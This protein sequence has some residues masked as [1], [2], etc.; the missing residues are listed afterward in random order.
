MIPATDLATV[1]DWTREQDITVTLVGDHKQLS[2]IGPSGLFPRMLQERP[3]AELD[4]NLRQRSEVGRE[5]AAFLRDG[6]TEAAFTLLADTGQLV[7]VA[8]QAEAERTLVDAWAERAATVDDSFERLATCGIESQRN[9]QV[10]I[11]NALARTTARDS[12]WLTGPDTRYRIRNDEVT[13]AVGDQMIVTRNIRRRDGTVLANG[14]R[15]IVEETP[16]AGLRIVTRDDTGQH[17]RDRL[18]PSQTVRST[19]HGYAMTTHKLQGQTVTSLVVDVGPDR[20]LSATYVA[21]TRHRDDVFAVVNI[22]DIA[23]GP[24]IERLIAAGPDA[25]RDAVIAITANRIRQRGFADSPT[26]HESIGRA[27]PTAA[28]T[29]FPDV[30]PD[31]YGQGLGLE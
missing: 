12:G 8:S 24:E 28:E 9:D 18:T 11:L 30:T 7:I 4:E 5:C 14:T 13:Y 20:D 21:F 22:A 27:L 1:L 15:G 23:T 17:R 6:D 16:S 25:R 3:A 31:T 19:R 26:A 2:S 29:T 10:D